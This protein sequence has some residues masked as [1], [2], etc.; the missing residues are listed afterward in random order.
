MDV[1]FPVS[2]EI[3]LSRHRRAV[4]IAA[5]L[6]LS[7]HLDNELP[8]ADTGFIRGDV[9]ESGALEITDAILTLQ[10]LFHGRAE[11]VRCADAADADDDGS[12]GLA[13]AIAG[14]SYLFSGGSTPAPPF[15]ACGEDP[16][17][18]ELGCA[19]GRA[20][21]RGGELTFLGISVAAEGLYFVV[22]R[23][24]TFAGEGKL[25]RAKQGVLET[26]ATLPDGT[27][28]GILFVERGLLK[29]PQGIHPARADEATRAS[30][31]AFVNSTSNGAGSCDIPGLL[32]AVDFASSSETEA[33][34]IFYVTDGAGLCGGDPAPYLAEMRARVTEANQGKAELHTVAI[35]EIDPFSEPHL[36]ALA[37]ENGGELH[38]VPWE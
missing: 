24:G 25:T 14:L 6:L 3:P 38:V 20:C 27:W 9:D 29:F 36:R 22:D 18:D 12:L 4:S 15:P 35:G 23:S 8:A 11:A 5:V 21:R 10:F 7:S 37:E 32:A 19:A 31:I 33:D 30:A 13:D 28:F 34:V 17:A 1:P 2:R 26:I 16:T